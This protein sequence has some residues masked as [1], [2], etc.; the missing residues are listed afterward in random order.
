MPVNVDFSLIVKNMISI[1][2][3]GHSFILKVLNAFYLMVTHVKK[4]NS[5][6]K[7]KVLKII[8]FNLNQ[9]T[10]F[11]FFIPLR[12]RYVYFKEVL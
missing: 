4:L 1:D 11:E 2:E 12:K 5:N 7:I 8:N 3:I 10:Q 6:F 9:R